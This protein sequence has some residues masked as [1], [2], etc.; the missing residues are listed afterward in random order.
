MF[1]CFYCLEIFLNFYILKIK[2]RNIKNI[3]KNPIKGENL[4]LIPVSFCFGSDCKKYGKKIF[5][6]FPIKSIVTGLVVSQ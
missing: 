6:R 2:Q 3:V 1:A 4:R 5:V